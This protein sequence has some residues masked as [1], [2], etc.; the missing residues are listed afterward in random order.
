MAVV[1]TKLT[2]K[3]G[4]FEKTA[5]KINY[6]F[7]KLQKQIDLQSKISELQED[8]DI[9]YCSVDEKGNVLLDPNGR[10]VF[11]KENLKARIRAIKDL[12]Q[13]EVFFEPY[14]IPSEELSVF[15]AE[16]LLELKGVFVP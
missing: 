8:I 10:Y 11:T 16:E 13:K 3:D 1:N 14:Y 7:W 6:A 9:E 15:T 5:S 2:I 4:R 12:D